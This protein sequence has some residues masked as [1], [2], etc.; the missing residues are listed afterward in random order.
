MVG[1]SWNKTILVTENLAVALFSHRHRDHSRTLWID[2]I[3]V[4]QSNLAERSQQVQQMGNVFRVVSQ[5]IAWVGNE[6]DKSSLALEIIESVGGN[7]EVDWDFQTMRPRNS[8]ATSN[9]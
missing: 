9:S 4:N 3:C 7:I 6:A 2:A 5:V 8:D 1:E